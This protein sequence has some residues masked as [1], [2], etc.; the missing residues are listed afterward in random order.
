VTDHSSPIDDDSGLPVDPTADPAPTLP[1]P[2]IHIDIETAQPAR[3]GDYLLGGGANFSV[4]R[5]VT[6]Y[7]TASLPGGTDAARMVVQAT[8][9]FQDRV[10]QYLAGEQGVRQYLNFRTRL[11]SG[12]KVHEIA[13]GIA[14]DSTI[15]YVFDDDVSLAHAHRLGKGTPAGPVSYVRGRLRD[16]GKLLQQVQGMLDFEKPVALLVFGAL[17]AIDDD[18]DADRTV[19]ALLDS[20]VSGSY[21]VVTHV[22]I[23]LPDGGLAEPLKRFEEKLAEGKLPQMTLRTR[24]K[25]SRFFDSLE[26]VEPG[27]V[28]VDQWRPDT[29]HALPSDSAMFIYGAVGRKP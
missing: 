23:D 11:P 8:S 19:A 20:V 4:D 28:P 22:V 3:M 13:H 25:V 29:N 24:D 9:A 18:D 21:L 2:P 5:E 6:D 26:L 1:N 12:P 7:I 15:V 17:V 14:P 10:V 27:I 16:I